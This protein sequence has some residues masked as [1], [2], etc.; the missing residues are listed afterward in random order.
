M[1]RRRRRKKRERKMN[2]KNNNNKPKKNRLHPYVY[3]FYFVLSKIY[4]SLVFK[5]CVFRTNQ[6]LQ[7][8][9]VNKG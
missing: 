8:K 1:L 7:V 6:T 9:V 2:K 5:I 3:Q 4:T